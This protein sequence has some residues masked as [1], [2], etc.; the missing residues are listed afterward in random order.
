MLYLH[1]L[2][3]VRM[4]YLL[5]PFQVVTKLDLKTKGQGSTQKKGFMLLAFLMQSHYPREA[6]PFL[7]I[8]DTDR[9][10]QIF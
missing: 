10:S 4:Y 1:F 6:R 2:K 3:Y 8:T 7:Q 9:Y 5:P